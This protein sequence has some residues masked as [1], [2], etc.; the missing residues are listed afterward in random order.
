MHGTANTGHTSRE[1][2]AGK[3]KELHAIKDLHWVMG[4]PASSRVGFARVGTGSLI[5]SHQGSCCFAREKKSQGTKKLR[6]P[7]RKDKRLFLCHGKEPATDLFA[8]YPLYCLGIGI[9]F[10]RIK[11]ACI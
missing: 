10:R 4:A 2:A 5:L 8:L 9:L 3:R 6:R 1:T 7:H 11:L